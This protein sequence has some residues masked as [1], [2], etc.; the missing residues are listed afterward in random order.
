M[1]RATPTEISSLMLAARVAEILPIISVRSGIPMVKG[2]HHDVMLIG[3]SIRTNS[4]LTL[5]TCHPPAKPVP[6]SL[7]VVTNG[8]S[9]EVKL[10]KVP[11]PGAGHF[12]LHSAPQLQEVAPSPDGVGA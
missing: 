2:H 3:M 11:L 10:T 9:N 12:E 1:S 4:R 7:T 6:L 8:N 5:A